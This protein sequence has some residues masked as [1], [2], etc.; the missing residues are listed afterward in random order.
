MNHFGAVL[1][2]QEGHD[3]FGLRTLDEL[4]FCGAVVGHAAGNAVALQVDNVDHVA[5][6]ELPLG[7][8]DPRGQQ[9][10][11]LLSECCRRTI[12]DD[13]LAARGQ[14]ADHPALA[15]LD[16]AGCGQEEGADGFA[17]S[18]PGDDIGYATFS[19]H[20]GDGRPH[21]QPR[22]LDLG[23]HAARAATGSGTSGHA[24]DLGVYLL[25]YRNQLGMRVF[26]G[27]GRVQPVDIAE[28]NEE[29]GIQKVGHH[30]RQIVV[31]A[32]LLLLDFVGSQHIVFVDDGHDAQR[33]KRE[34]RIA[35]VEVSRPVGKLPL[36]EQR[37]GYDDAMPVEK[38]LIGVHQASLPHGCQNLPEG[39]VLPVVVRG[40]L[41]APGGYG[42]RG[43][44]HYLP[45]LLVKLGDLVHQARHG[46]NV[47]TS[48]AAGEE[49]RPQLDHQAVILAVLLR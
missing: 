36:G 44:Q 25:H 43:H 46:G 22:G 20:H 1:I 11:L 28:Q 2:S 26:A 13:Y 32:E 19:D 4:D 39:Y 35:G 48:G 3:L 37:L 24:L 34:D 38:L 17:I 14:S 27:I 15:A 16:F 18:Q 30:G 21:R 45:S 8:F 6:A 33:H 10:P 7:V 40:Q 29:V 42:P 12:I 31:V 49:V 23:S 9:T 41:V 5:A 47:E